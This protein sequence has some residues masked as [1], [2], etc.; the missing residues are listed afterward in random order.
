[1]HGL[2][3]VEENV[4]SLPGSTNSVIMVY[5]EEPFFLGWQKITAPYAEKTHA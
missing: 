1:L 3:G 4:G 2:C 5:E